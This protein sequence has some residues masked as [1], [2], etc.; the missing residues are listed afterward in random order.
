MNYIV[1]TAEEQQE[2][3][4]ALRLEHIE[5]LYDGIPSGAR[6][7][8]DLNLPHGITEFEAADHMK[9]LAGMNRIYPTIFRGAGAYRH[10]I[11]AAVKHITSLSGYVTAYTPYQAELSQGILQGMFEYQTMIADLTGMDAANASVYDGAEAAAEAMIM[12]LEIHKN[13]ILVSETICPEVLAVLHTYAHAKDAE[14]VMIPSLDGQTDIEKMKQLLTDETACVYTEQPNFNGLIEDVRAIADAAHAQKV[15]VITGVNPTAMALLKTPGECGSDIAV[16]EGQS[17][18][19]DLS[20][21]GPYCGFMA[22]RTAMMRKL[23]GRIVGQTSDRHGKRCF[24]LTL[25]AREQHIR[26]EKASSSIC[27]NQALCAF[28]NS[29]YLASLGK[30]GFVEMAQNCVTLAHYAAEKIAAVDGYS[31]VYPGEFFMEFAVHTPIGVSKINAMLH[32]HDILGGYQIDDQTMLMCVTEANT[33]AEID[34]LVSLL[35]EV[36]V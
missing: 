17:L 26:R 12:C 2:M 25:Q 36:Q 10:L 21:G 14:I 8:R 18:G 19:L 34:K 29:V 24:V 31:L 27:S 11:P 15:K 6:L 4:K 16:G 28:R 1:N 30:N 9:K 23:P 3:L 20:F 7:N 13:K 33:A 22:T 5:D 32:E 35:K